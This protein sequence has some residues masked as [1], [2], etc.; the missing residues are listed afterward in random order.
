MIRPWRRRSLTCR[1]AFAVMSDYLDG[2]LPEG[3]RS[4][5]DRHLAACPMCV[6]YLAQLRATVGALGRAEPDTLPDE[7]VAELVDLYRHWRDDRGDD[8]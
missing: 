4:R 2:R 8:A 7:A 5:L 1:R 6:E 3:D